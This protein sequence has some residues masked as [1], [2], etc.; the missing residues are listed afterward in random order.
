M[1]NRW[2]EYDIQ[3]E[4]REL[5]KG[6]YPEFPNELEIAGGGKT[7]SEALKRNIK[8]DKE[9]GKYIKKLYKIKSFKKVMEIK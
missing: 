2:N 5:F 6:N 4:K 3:L 7:P 8:M 9:F 1:K